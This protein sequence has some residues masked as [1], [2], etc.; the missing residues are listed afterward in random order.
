M[1]E[2]LAQ[3]YKKAAENGIKDFTDYYQTLF[4]LYSRRAELLKLQ[5]SLVGQVIA[6]EIAS[7]RYLPA[8]KSSNKF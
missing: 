1:L 7:G 2:Q 4:D 3:N 5:S 6:L 8:E